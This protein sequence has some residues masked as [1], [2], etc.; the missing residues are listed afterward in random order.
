MGYGEQT[1]IIK[2]SVDASEAHKEI[3]SL[4]KTM[5]GL[6]RARRRWLDIVR[7]CLVAV[8]AVAVVVLAVAEL[9]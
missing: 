3:D 1:H 7:D 8:T 5:R 6:R 2:L 9:V 4:Q